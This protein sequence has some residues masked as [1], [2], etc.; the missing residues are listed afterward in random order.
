MVAITAFSLLICL[1]HPAPPA[2]SWRP[3]TP[4]EWAVLS[5]GIGVVGGALFHLFL[6][7]ERDLDRLFISLS[8]AIILASGAAA[9]LGLSPLFPTM[10]IG[11]VLINTSPNRDQLRQ[12][13]GKVERPFYLVLLLFAGAAWEPP[14]GGPRVALVLT[15]ALFLIARMA[16]NLGSARLATRLSWMLPELGPGWGRALLGH[17][18]LALA[19]GLNYV[20]LEFAVMPHL[21]FTATVASVLLTHLFSA[22]LV[23]AVARTDVALFVAP[24]AGDTWQPDDPEPARS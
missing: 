2:T 24:N 11:M 21:V 19:I 16:A 13:L 15:V 6:G 9:Y 17:G 14:V 4:T 8:G 7:R 1:V 12:A 5:V 23:R 18:E 10:L 3:P 22:R 20:F